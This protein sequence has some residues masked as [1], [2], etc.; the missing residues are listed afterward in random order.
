MLAGGA[1]AGLATALVDGPGAPS[2]AAALWAGTVGAGFGATLASRDVALGRRLAAVALVAA[3]PGAFVLLRS[4]GGGSAGLAAL[5]VALAVA[6][7]VGAGWR[8]L[9]AVLAV[10][11]GFVYAAGWA[12][13]EVATAR[14]LVGVPGWVQGTLAAATVGLGSVAALLPGHVWYVRAGAPAAVPAAP[15]AADPELR[16]LLARAQRVR[17]GVAGRLGADDRHLLEAG[18]AQ[19]A[20]LAVRCEALDPGDEA[21]VLRQRHAELQDRIARCDDEVARR[22]YG[23]ALTTVEAQ[24]RL[25]A[26]TAAA[27]QRVVAGMHA[28][29]TTLERFRQAVAHRDGQAAA[30]QSTRVASA[31]LA[32]LAAELDTTA[33]EPAAAA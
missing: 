6:L 2:A 31:Q 16:D 17:D 30:A 19:L 27:R 20:T 10:G 1:L 33:S 28:W 15:A 26:A 22:Q 7:H 21:A 13:G 9:P 32:Q 3:A 12:A 24:Q 11:G 18:L 29:V 25:S 4:W 5:A 23:A 14:E 8:R